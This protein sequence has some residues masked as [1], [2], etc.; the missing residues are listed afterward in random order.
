M[1]R[2]IDYINLNRYETSR[3]HSDRFQPTL[4]SVVRPRD[5]I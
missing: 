2:R 1:I 4:T 3:F 5:E